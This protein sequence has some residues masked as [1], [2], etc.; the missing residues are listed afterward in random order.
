VGED[1]RRYLGL[2]PSRPLGRR[3]SALI[4]YCRSTI[5]AEIVPAPVAE[6]NDT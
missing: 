2:S 3:P 5:C 6:M 4:V 1:D